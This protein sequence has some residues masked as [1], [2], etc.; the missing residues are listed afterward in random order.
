ME[1]L[2]EKTVDA[3]NSDT[4][5]TGKNK[6]FIGDYPVSQGI[7]FFLLGDILPGENIIVQYPDENEWRPFIMFGNTLSLNSNNTVLTLTGR[8]SVRLSK[9]VTAN[10]VGVGIVG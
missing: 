4:V 1:I 3:V 9:S 8:A 6:Y 2:I 7:T 10:P 5:S